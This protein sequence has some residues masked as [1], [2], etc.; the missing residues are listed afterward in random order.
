MEG[1]NIYLH[2]LESAA[3]TTA[4]CAP[5]RRQVKEAGHTYGKSSAHGLDTMVAFPS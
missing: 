5:K 2:L 3:G 1:G 4:V